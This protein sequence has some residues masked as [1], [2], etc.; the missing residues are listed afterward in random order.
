[1]DPETG[2]PIN[3]IQQHGSDSGIERTL[4]TNYDRI[5][6]SRM[7]VGKKYY[8]AVTAYTYNSDPQAN[9]NNSESLISIIEAVFYDGLGGAGNGDSVQVLH[10]AGFGDGNVYVVVDNPTQLT[11]ND[12]EVYFDKQMYYRNENGVWVPIPPGRI[13][14]GSITDDLTGSTVDIGAV[15]GPS[16]GVIELG[17]YFNYVSSDGNW[18]DGISMT[19]PA[20]ITIIDAPPFEAGGGIVTPEIIGN[21]IN[22][23]IVNGSQ[24]EDG[25][26]HGGEDWTIFILISCPSMIS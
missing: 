14:G 7:L 6:N 21:T 11:G 4:A 26:F 9:P 18:A 22:M 15:Y 3:G 25:I 16:A 12:Y 1:M 19:F 5:E 13:R 23:G 17:C 24:T 8:F 10:S 20:G 2:L